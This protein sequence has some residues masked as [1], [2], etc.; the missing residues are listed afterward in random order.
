MNNSCNYADFIGMDLSSDNEYGT[1]D[2]ELEIQPMSYSQ[3]SS[4]ETRIEHILLNHNKYHIYC[5]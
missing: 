5:E 1:Y 2:Y 3:E 4:V